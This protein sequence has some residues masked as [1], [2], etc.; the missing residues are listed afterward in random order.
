[1][2]KP[3]EK[4]DMSEIR[5]T[6]EIRTDFECEA[7]G[8]P[9]ERWGEAVFKIQDQEI[10]L[11][12]S[13]EKEIIVAIMVDEATAWKGTLAGLR[14]LLKNANAGPGSQIG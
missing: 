7:T 3:R 6:A 8:L 12:V 11:E 10:V 14:Q 13:V 9:A 1:M 2:I 5:M 4:I